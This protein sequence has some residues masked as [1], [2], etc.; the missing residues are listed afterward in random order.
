MI[1]DI[2]YPAQM[3]TRCADPE[4]Q[5]DVDLMVL[6]YTLF[7]AV[8]AHL[9]A[10]CE[11]RCQHDYEDDDDKAMY[12]PQQ[13]MLVIFDGFLKV[14]NHHHPCYEQSAEFN[15]RQQILE[16]LVLLLYR[17]TQ[18]TAMERSSANSSRVDSRAINDLKNRRR[19]LARRERDSRVGIHKDY[20]AAGEADKE[21]AW[22]LE[23]RIYNTWDATRLPHAPSASPPTALPSSP[24]LLS[25]LLPRFMAISASFVDV[26]R[27]RPDDFWMDVA[28]EFMLQ[29]SLESLQLRSRGG[30]SIECLPRLADCFAW[31]YLGDLDTSLNGEGDAHPASYDNHGH[32]ETAEK[33]TEA[34]N[35]LFRS[36]PAECSRDVE[37][38]SWTQ[39]RLDTL[40]EFSVIGGDSFTAASVASQT[41]RLER[42]IEKYPRAEFQHR[43]ALLLRAMWEFSCREHLLGKP[44][45]VEI[46]EGH[47]KSRALEG[48]EFA[49]FAAR[50][51]LACGVGG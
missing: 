27:Q 37:H 50:V 17:R 36:S 18:I 34:F 41:P 29:A 5:L 12:G 30:G 45:L 11:G 14:F 9:E 22:N 43:L 23:Q 40:Q 21:R 51:G 49:Q 46:E 31:G 39:L 16:L 35:N 44:V 2:R 4:L 3:D 7:R 28:C 6:E 32:K 26:V 10:L 15:Y 8:E 24:S 47:V 19:W 42:L 38:P 13:R 25:P 33:E 48:A 20:T 1:D